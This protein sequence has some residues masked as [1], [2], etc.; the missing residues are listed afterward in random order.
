MKL[1][2]DL[3]DWEI[4]RE[5]FGKNTKLE[6]HLIKVLRKNHYKLTELCEG[7]FLLT[8]ETDEVGWLV[9]ENVVE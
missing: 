6:C 5:I 2:T 8:T 9:P 4:A 3:K 7:Y 1:K